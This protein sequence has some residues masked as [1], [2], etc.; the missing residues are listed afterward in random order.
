VVA[1]LA[2]GELALR[3]AVKGGVVGVEGDSA[4]AKGLR[5]E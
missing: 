1:G 3:A 4:V 2:S 5:G